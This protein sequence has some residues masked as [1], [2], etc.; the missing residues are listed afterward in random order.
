MGRRACQLKSLTLTRAACLSIVASAAE[1][2]PKEC[3]GSICSL[4]RPVV[5]G[6]IEA[7]FPYQIAT[8]KS[9]QVTSCSS[10]L[11]FDMLGRGGPWVKVG[12]FHSH[13]YTRKLDVLEPSEVDLDNMEIGD[14]EVIVRVHRNKH[15]SNSWKASRGSI[16]VSWGK[17]RFLIKAFMRLEGFDKEGVPLYSIVPLDLRD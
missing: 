16:R 4:S 13:T 3:M 14:V 15:R 12:D 10:F 1:V 9:E 5:T 8:R 2:F 7:A 11:F 17:F 6:E